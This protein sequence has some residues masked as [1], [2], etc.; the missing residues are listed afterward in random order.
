MIK[1]RLDGNFIVFFFVFI[2]KTTT[3]F[4]EINCT[5]LQLTFLFQQKKILQPLFIYFY[6]TA[7]VIIK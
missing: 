3:L 1:L 4:F 7:C 5:Y 2:K 6:L